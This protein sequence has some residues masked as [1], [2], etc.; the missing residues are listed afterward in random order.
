MNWTV[1]GTAT[2]CKEDV[3][4]ADDVCEHLQV[5]ATAIYVGEQDNFGPVTRYWKCKECYREY[6]AKEAEMIVALAEE[7]DDP[8]SGW[9]L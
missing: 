1:K 9:P 8:E 5:G 4:D 3:E 2:L 7:H 6:L